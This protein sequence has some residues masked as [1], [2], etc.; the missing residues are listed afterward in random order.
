MSSY[1][2]PFCKTEIEDNIDSLNEHRKTD[3]EC[4]QKML[5]R[6]S[7]PACGRPARKDP[8]QDNT[9]YC[10]TVGCNFMGIKE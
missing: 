2:C 7:C 8:R 4:D 5:I 3:G 6:T 1:K 9:I 10:N